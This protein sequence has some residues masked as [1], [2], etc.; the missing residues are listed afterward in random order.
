MSSSVGNVAWDA[1]TINLNHYT[2]GKGNLCTPTEDNSVILCLSE[3]DVYK[4]RNLENQACGIRVHM[5][6]PCPN[7]HP[8]DGYW[9]TR[10]GSSYPFWY[11]EVCMWHEALWAE[12]RLIIS[13]IVCIFKVLVWLMFKCVQVSTNWCN[14][15]F[16]S[17]HLRN[18]IYWLRLQMRHACD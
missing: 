12:L 14:V 6:V 9:A 16:M 4:N 5:K 13:S 10:A 3:Y 15:T 11:E 8:W 18:Y 17:N 2:T 7:L 1:R